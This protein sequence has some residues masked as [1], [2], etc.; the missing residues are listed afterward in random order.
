MWVT[1]DFPNYRSPIIEKFLNRVIGYIDFLFYFLDFALGRS[2]GCQVPT[3]IGV[4]ER[5]QGSRG[6]RQRASSPMHR[7]TARCN[8]IAACMAWRLEPQKYREV[9]KLVFLEFNRTHMSPFHSLIQFLIIEVN[10]H[11][12]QDLIYCA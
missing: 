5:E 9:P 8:Y 11:C 4:G 6:Q 2:V 12:R 1:L 7:L 3:T 10:Q